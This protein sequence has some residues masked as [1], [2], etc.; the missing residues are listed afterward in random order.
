MT[1]N[2]GPAQNF[3]VYADV[4]TQ[5]LENVTVVVY[6]VGTI[7]EHTWQLLKRKFEIR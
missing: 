3:A 1:E 6:A 4:A 7:T 2:D 5:G